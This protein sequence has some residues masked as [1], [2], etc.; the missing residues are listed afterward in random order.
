MATINYCDGVYMR[1]DA[2]ESVS[3][4]RHSLKKGAEIMIKWLK[5]YL[6]KKGLLAG[7]S[8][9]WESITIK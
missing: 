7:V 1:S 4:D 3:G 2:R 8:S 6:I 9:D 5:D